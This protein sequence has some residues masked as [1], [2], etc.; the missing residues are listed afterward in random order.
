MPAWGYARGQQRQADVTGSS[1]FAG[2]S[3]PVCP[4]RWL[5]VANLTVLK[6]EAHGRSH[7][8]PAEVAGGSRVDVDESVL[9]VP[10]DFE[11]VGVP[12][13]EQAGRVSGKRL[14]DALVVIAR[15]AADVGDPYPDSF[16][17]EALVEWKQR[18]RVAPSTFPADGFK[19]LE[20]PQRVGEFDCSMSPACQI[21]SH[22]SKYSKMLGSRYPWVSEIKPMR[23]MAMQVEVSHYA[24]SVA[25]K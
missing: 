20:F 8:V 22:F 14:P 11:D 13:D 21:S 4:V 24:G 18:R 15:V 7:D 2:A 5:P 16:A 10:H 6:R 3:C 19:R 23:F 12:A 9:L 17:F 25:A 1:S